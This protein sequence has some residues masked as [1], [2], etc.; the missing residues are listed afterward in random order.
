M[1][2]ANEVS[3]AT[4]VRIPENSNFAAFGVDGTLYYRVSL[5]L[6]SSKVIVPT[7]LTNDPNEAK[8]KISF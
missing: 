5:Y 7:I 8:E 6:V 2:D 3:S 4:Q 1:N